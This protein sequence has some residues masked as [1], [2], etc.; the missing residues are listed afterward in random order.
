MFLVR[1]ERD[2][3]ARTDGTQLTHDPCGHC[4]NWHFAAARRPFAAAAHIF[5]SL[6]L[7]RC[8]L[9]PSRSGSMA[10]AAVPQV[11]R[12]S[13]GYFSLHFSPAAAAIRSEKESLDSGPLLGYSSPGFLA[14]LGKCHGENG[15][16]KWPGIDRSVGRSGKM[17]RQFLRCSYLLIRKYK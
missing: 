15:T 14:V 1:P 2:L 5:V 17:C 7:Y 4:S 6:A 16:G 11:W 3:L 9:W 13:A 8:A 10:D 12:Q